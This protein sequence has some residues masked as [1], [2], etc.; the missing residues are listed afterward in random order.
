M[1]T[2]EQRH[3]TTGCRTQGRSH[4]GRRRNALHRVDGL[5]VG[6]RSALPLV[7][8]HALLDTFLC[9]FHSSGFH[10]AAQCIAGEALGTGH[11]ALGPH[12]P[13]DTTNDGR[14][15]AGLA[16]CSQCLLVRGT[17]LGGQLIGRA[18]SITARHGSTC[19]STTHQAAACCVQACDGCQRAPA[20]YGST[21]PSEGTHRLGSCQAGVVHHVAAHRA[22]LAHHA[23]GVGHI[24]LEAL[25]LC[26]DRIALA[27]LARLD[28]VLVDPARDSIA[29]PD[30]VGRSGH[31][32]GS[33]VGHLD[34]RVV[35]DS[36]ERASLGWRVQERINLAGLASGRLR[37]RR[38]VEE[39]VDLAHPPMVPAHE[40]GRKPQW[41]AAR[42]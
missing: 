31:A 33:S 23:I 12:H 8:G 27:G 28:D 17:A 30:E 36:G 2:R 40:P 9:T 19:S 7:L 18:S 39:V 14:D 26:L 10:G 15:D 5:V 29:R 38:A 11:Q 35:G 16:P 32:T 20:L 3:A 41:G 21:R 4:A 25:L 13:A 37:G 34:H 1:A 42:T 6:H 24:L 22:Q